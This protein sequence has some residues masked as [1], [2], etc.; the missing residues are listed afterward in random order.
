M[1]LRLDSAATS[2]SLVPDLVTGLV[3]G[4][5]QALFGVVVL[6]SRDVRKRARAESALAEALAFRKAMEDSVVT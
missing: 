4:L 3:I 2:P 1:Q 5:S 6:L